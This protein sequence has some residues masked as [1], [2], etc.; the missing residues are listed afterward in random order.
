MSGN[1]FDDES[2]TFCVLVNDEE[3]HS[4]WPTFTQVPQGWRVVF[5]ADGQTP[6]QECLDYIDKNW[7][8]LRP[9]SLRESMARADEAQAGTSHTLSAS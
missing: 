5:G 2:G 6:R 7:T 4:L 8:D 3:Q 9:R 1:P